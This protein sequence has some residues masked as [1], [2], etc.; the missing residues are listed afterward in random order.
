[1]RLAFFTP[2]LAGRGGIET[3]LV[4]LLGQLHQEGSDAR[5]FIFGGSKEKDWLQN[6]PWVKEIEQARL[7]KPARL[8]FYLQQALS[9]LRRWQPDAIVCTYPTTLQLARTCKSILMLKDVPAILWLHGPLAVHRNIERA[10]PMA[11]GHICICKERSEEVKAALSR[12]APDLDPPVCIAYNGT[13]AAPKQTIEPAGTPTFVYVGRFLYGEEK[14]VGDILKAAAQLHGDFRIRLIGDGPAEEK[15]KLQ[16]LAD[17]LDL[18]ESV[19]WLGWHSDPWAAAG[20]ATALVLAS[21]YEGFGMVVVEA[22]SHGL[23]VISSEFGPSVREL[24]EP[25]KTGWLFPVGDF[26]ALGS[27]MQSLIDGTTTLPNRAEIRIAGAKFSTENMA[28]S[29]R[30]GIQLMISRKVQAG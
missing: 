10:L 3:V 28:A 5:L 15:R 9:E 13:A 6:L 17:R 24:I 20:N 1:M 23:P 22:M 16:E 18:S 25:G 21:S 4:N 27:I 29:F 2:G 8:F 7:P 30:S 19:E 26:A 12:L 11:D 14:N